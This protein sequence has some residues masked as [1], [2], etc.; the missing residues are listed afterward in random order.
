M[1]CWQLIKREHNASPIA[2]DVFIESTQ[3]CGHDGA[4]VLT[5]PSRSSVCPECGT[6]FGVR[7]DRVIHIKRKGAQLLVTG[8]VAYVC[9]R[10]SEL[11]HTEAGPALELRRPSMTEE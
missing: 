3:A 8:Q 9:P 1:F 7:S 5:T 6:L 11:N 10:C 2:C 4:R